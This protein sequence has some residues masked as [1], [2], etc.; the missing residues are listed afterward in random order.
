MGAFPNPA[1][2]MLVITWDAGSSGILQVINPVG[3]K[4]WQQTIQNNQDRQQ[5]DTKNLKVGTYAIRLVSNQ[6]TLMSQVLII[7]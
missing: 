7:H 4:V 2:Q 3:T 1:D 6:R 5:I